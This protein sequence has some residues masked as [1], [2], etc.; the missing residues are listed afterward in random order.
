MKKRISLL[1]IV[2]LAISLLAGCE[3]AKET[4]S[5]KDKNKVTK[6]G[7]IQ[8]TQHV[9]LD[10]AY[11]GFVAGLKDAG[12][13]DGKNIKLDFNNAQGDQSNC[14]TIAQKLVNDKDDLIL[15][16]ATP[17]AQSCASKTKDIPIL[18]TAVTDPKTSGL[19]KTN[20]KPG[21]NVTGTSDLTPV[22]EQIALLK[23]ILPNAKK[24]G[25]LYCSSEDNSIF[26]ADI[27]KKEIQAN[28]ME[29]VE[30]TVSNTNEIASVTQ[31]L[32]GKV[33]VIYTPTDNMIAQ[34]MPNIAK[35]ATASKIPCIVGEEGMVKNGGLA[36][37]GIDYYKLGKQTAAMAVKILKGEAKPEDMSIEYLKDCTL[38]V[39]EKAAKELGITLPKDLK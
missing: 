29:V 31:S 21:N 12:Y 20:E 27:A 6:I 26:Q 36:T 2:I 23:K 39:N 19:V 30:A 38:K 9:A 32:V 24:V 1:L 25:V 35:I 34:G 14:T 17:A 18:I 33:D 13:E 22:K 37:Y 10:A 28:G 5:K 8:L 11:K 7:I 16:I 3:S 15:A 4:S